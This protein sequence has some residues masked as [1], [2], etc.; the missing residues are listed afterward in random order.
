MDLAGSVFGRGGSRRV[1]Y[2]NPAAPVCR[3]FQLGCVGSTVVAWSWNVCNCILYCTQDHAK[4]PLF[5]A[6]SFD[7]QTVDNP[8]DIICIKPTKKQSFSTL[9]F[10]Q[11]LTK[12][13]CCC[14]I[15]LVLTNSGGT[16]ATWGRWGGTA[17][18]SLP[19]RKGVNANGQE[20][21]AEDRDQHHRLD[22]GH[23][24]GDY[25]CFNSVLTARLA[26]ERLT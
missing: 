10:R 7:S 15:M 25:L 9:L 1:G 24:S 11:Y 12:R 22:R 6:I 4:L 17:V 2:V 18:S 5:Q 14:T 3:G 8:L 26:P 19:C 23:R 20:K 16:M 13:V 21:A